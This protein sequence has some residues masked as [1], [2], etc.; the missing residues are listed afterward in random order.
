MA[1]APVRVEVHRAHRLDAA[2]E[3]GVSVE[4]VDE[5]GV[6]PPEPR[7][8]LQAF[9]ER[10]RRIEPRY[11]AQPT[12]KALSRVAGNVGAQRVAQQVK[13][14]QMKVPLLVIIFRESVHQKLNLNGDHGAHDAG[15]DDRL[16]VEAPGAPGPVDDDHIEVVVVE[17]PVLHCHRPR[18]IVHGVVEAVNEHLCGQLCLEVPFQL[19]R[20]LVK[21]QNHF[22][23]AVRSGE[24]Q[25]S[26]SNGVRRFRE[27]GGR[28]GTKYGMVKVSGVKSSNAG[29]GYREAANC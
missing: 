17:P 1:D 11:L 7:L 14:A 5:G 29:V 21:G 22:R 26:G 24:E 9:E 18:G 16:V 19:R 27:K 2:L 23:V 13:A 10:P 15:V 20:A 3:E 12:G 8:R 28:K 6:R 25:K 4:D